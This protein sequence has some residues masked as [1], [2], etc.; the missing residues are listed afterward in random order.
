MNEADLN[1]TL[2]ENFIQQLIDDFARY[3]VE[4]HYA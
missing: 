2:T 1:S 3:D 4:V